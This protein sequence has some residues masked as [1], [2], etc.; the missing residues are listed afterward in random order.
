MAKP[1]TTAPVEGGLDIK[2]IKIGRARFCILGTTPLIY[3]A[4][5]THAVKSLLFPPPPKNRAERA[6]TVK[7]N[8]VQEF[9]DSCYL[10]REDSGD[11]PTRLFVPTTFWKG[12]IANAALDIPGATKAQVGR[13]VKVTGDHSPIWGLPKVWMSMVK[14]GGMNA[15]PDIR[16]RARLETWASV[17][18]VEFMAGHFKSS[19]L[20]NLLEAAGTL[21]G[22]GDFRQQKGKGDFGCFTIVSH[23]DPEYLKILRFGRVAQDQALKAALPADVDTGRLLDWYGEELARRRDPDYDG[24]EEVVLAAPKKANGKTQTHVNAQ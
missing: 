8:P 20:A 6:T 17:V 12:T 24:D 4:P 9:R 19:D 7:H 18:E 1:K 21:V 10:E 15:A 16:T 13:L 11:T 2:P 5:S 14:N 23:D 3:N 22:I